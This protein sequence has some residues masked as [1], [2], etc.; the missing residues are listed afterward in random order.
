M[1]PRN[2]I[3]SSG[4]C[5]EKLSLLDTCQMQLFRLHSMPNFELGKQE[6]RNKTEHVYKGF[7][8]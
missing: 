2:S 8:G 5:H 1:V 6:T 3:H 4:T 7:K